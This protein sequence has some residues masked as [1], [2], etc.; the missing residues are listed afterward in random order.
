MKHDLRL[1]NISE[2]E[3]ICRKNCLKCLNQVWKDSQ[4]AIKHLQAGLGLGLI[5]IDELIFIFMF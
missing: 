3:L 2:V 5:N 4:L 1:S